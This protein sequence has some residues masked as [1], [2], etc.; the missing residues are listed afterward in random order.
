M[1]TLYMSMYVCI[2]TYIQMYV[3]ALMREC[4][5]MYVHFSIFKPETIL[6]TYICMYLCTY[7]NTYT[8]CI[9]VT[10]KL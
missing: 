2:C 8:G 9:Q 3:E 7:I 10:L 4:T 1:Y 5:S 6:Y